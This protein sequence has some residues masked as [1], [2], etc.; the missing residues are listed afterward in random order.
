V[1]L[2]FSYADFGE[3]THATG[4]ERL[5]FDVMVGDSTLFHREDMV[6]AAWRIAT[7]ILDLWSALPAREFPNYA[8]GTWGPAA[9]DELLE[10]EGHHWIAPG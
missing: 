6:D 4:Y 5:L 10:R 7:P 1:H 2:D 3:Q 8:P 9:G